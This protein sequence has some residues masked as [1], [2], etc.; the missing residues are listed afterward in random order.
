MGK[1]GNQE[2][3]NKENNEQTKKEN[4]KSGSER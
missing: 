2:Q 3:R 1:S 4:G